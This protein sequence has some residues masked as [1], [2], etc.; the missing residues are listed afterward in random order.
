MLKK[1]KK[2]RDFGSYRSFTL[3]V[4]VFEKVDSLRRVI[5]EYWAF[6]IIIYLFGV[7]WGGPWSFDTTA[8]LS[9]FLLISLL[10]IIQMY[11]KRCT[12]FYPLPLDSA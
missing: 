12:A 10:I 5:D 9:L 1:R 8:F 3:I 7:L 2:N 11:R 4:A 6:F